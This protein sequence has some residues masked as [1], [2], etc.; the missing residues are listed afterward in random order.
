MGGSS[1]AKTYSLVQRVAVDTFAK[2]TNTMILRK[3]GSDIEDSIYSDAKGIIN[4]WNLKPYFIQIQ[5]KIKSKTG[6]LMRFRGLDDSEKVKGIAQFK[7]VVLEELSQFDEADLKQIRKRLRGQ[8]GQQII[9]IWNPIDENHWIK[10]NVLDKDEWIE[11]PRTVQGREY[12]TL[13]DNSYVKIN[14]TGN[15]ILIKT[16]YRDNYWITGHPDGKH[17]FTDKHVLQ[18]FEDDKKNDYEYYRVYANGEWGKLD[19]GGEI[20]KAFNVGNNVKKKPY[21][22][23]LPIHASFD[24]NVVP[25]MT[26]LLF[27]GEGREAWQIGE[28]CLPNPRNSLEHTCS[29][30]KKQYPN[31]KAGLF[32]YGDATSRKADTKLEKGKNFYTLVREYLTQYKP[33]MRVD[34][35]NPSVVMRCMFANELFSGKIEGCTVY[36]DPD[37]TNTVEDLKYTK[38]AADGGKLKERVKNKDTGQSYEKYGHCSD[39]FDYFATKFFQS[40]YNDYLRGGR[41]SVKYSLSKSRRNSRR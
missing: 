6:G 19:T 33:T 30:F 20:Y 36:L 27:Q 13:D 1:A 37:C 29:E 7:R 31:H 3:Y 18:D 2:K 8:E 9:G 10:K 12:S 41:K 38:E 4:D 35:S 22:P 23:A 40:E 39:A 34:A 5:N 14:G 21:N 11:A 17:G 16:T 28:I 32:I 24:E 15:S 25:Y 26:M